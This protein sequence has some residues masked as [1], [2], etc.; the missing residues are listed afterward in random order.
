MSYPIENMNNNGFIKRTIYSIFGC[1]ILGHSW[2]APST[3]PCVHRCESCGTIEYWC[4][5]YKII[6][7]GA[8]KDCEISVCVGC[9][10]RHT[11]YKGVLQ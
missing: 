6:S 10:R 5:Q 11:V 8:N 3:C 2:S 7:V 1:N 9:G 4:K